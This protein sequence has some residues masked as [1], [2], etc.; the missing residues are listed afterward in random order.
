MLTDKLVIV[1]LRYC[2]IIKIRNDGR[3]FD[4]KKWRFFD[5]EKKFNIALPYGR[6]T[7]AYFNYIQNE[8]VILEKIGHEKIHFHRCNTKST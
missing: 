3:L 6:D 4:M 8:L 2:L 7:Y 5:L 1:G